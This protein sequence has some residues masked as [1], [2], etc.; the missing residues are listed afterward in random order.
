MLVMFD[1]AKKGFSNSNGYK[2]R[3]RTLGIEG[4]ITKDEYDDSAIMHNN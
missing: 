3:K 2:F 1:W 4:A